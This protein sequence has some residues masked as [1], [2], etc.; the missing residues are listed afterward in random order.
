MKSST[1]TPHLSVIVPVYNEEESVIPLAREIEAAMADFTGEWECVWIDDGSSDGTLD[2]LRELASESAATGG[3]PHRPVMHD[4]NYGQSPALFTG[5]RRARGA[6]FITLD[7]DGQND[8]ADIPFLIRRLEESGADMVNGR[9]RKRRDSL[10]RL[11]CS[12]IANGFRNWATKERVSDVGCSLRAFHRR[13]VEHIP[14]FNGMH[15]FLPTLARLC[16][17]ANIIEEPVNHRPRERGVTKYGINNRLWVGLRDTFAVRWMQSRV[18]IPSSLPVDAE[19][20]REKRKSI[21][22]TLQSSS[23]SHD[24]QAGPDDRDDRKVVREER[25]EKERS[26]LS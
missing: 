1:S 18:R 16:G 2:R 26:S 5:F 7:G 25:E 24:T 6:I 9:R 20:G 17:H 21:A 15:R 11:V 22:P 23:A 8:P 14:V 13:C 12:R 3:L 10:V 19:A 4:R